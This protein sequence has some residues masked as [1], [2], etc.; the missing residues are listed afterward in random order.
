ME[1]GYDETEEMHIMY[2]TEVYKLNCLDIAL[3]QASIA[4][5]NTMRT[6]IAIAARNSYLQVPI[7][8]CVW[9]GVCCGV[10]WYGVCVCV[11]YSLVVIYL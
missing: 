2:C 3:K 4:V 9:C 6:M 7:Y 8:I 10:V 5:T 1:G 11:S